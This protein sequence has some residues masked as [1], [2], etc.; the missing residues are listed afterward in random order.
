MNVENNIKSLLV[1]SSV[2]LLFFLQESWSDDKA[3]NLEN[4]LIKKSRDLNISQSYYWKKL[5]HYYN[6]SSL[7]KSKSFFLSDK[8]SNNLQSELEGNLRA[9]LDKDISKQ[10]DHNICKFPARF[11]FILKSL[12]VDRKTFPNPKC[13]KYKNHISKI[14]ANNL[15]ISFASESAN[16][17]ISMMGHVFLKISGTTKEGRD[18]SHALG[19]FADFRKSSVFSIIFGSISKGVDGLYLLEPYKKKLELY[20]IKQ[21]RNVWNYNI[22]LSSTQID[23]L[24][25]HIWELKNANVTYHFITNNCGS[26]LLNLLSLVEEKLDNYDILFDAPIDIIKRLYEIGYIKSVELVPSDIGKYQVLSKNLTRQDKK[27]ILA[28][29]E[30]DDKRDFY[31]KN[32]SNK[33]DNI[34]YV[35]DLVNEHKLSKKPQKYQEDY[36]V[37][38]EIIDEEFTNLG[39]TNLNLDIRNPINKT[40]SSVLDFG[41]ESRKS[42]NEYLRFGFYPVYNDIKDDN[43]NYFNEFDLQLLNLNAFYNINED[44]LLFEKL[45]I[46]KIKNINDYDLIF[47]GLSKSLNISLERQKL[48]SLSN[49]MFFDGNAGLGYGDRLFDDLLVYAISKVGL[50]NFASNDIIYLNPEVGLIYQNKNSD[51]K[52]ILKLQKFYANDDF[53][54][55]NLYEFNQI[56]YLNSNSEIILKYQMIDPTLETKF[57]IFGLDY[58]YHF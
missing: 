14:A 17:V 39:N 40:Y 49:K 31:R 47:S 51:F 13:T 33:N 9:F 42:N 34:L 12:G 18:V 58:R 8:G 19:Y 7:V 15:S 48:N 20:N 29:F 2:F 38:K 41:Y 25:D 24:V 56:Y 5:L 54:Y 6:G 16:S 35:I 44:R 45:D 28:F 55:E 4:D 10:D 11:Q 57:D 23:K 27:N 26:A 32:F 3:L 36:V 30:K 50:S 52:T 53:K 43:S 1:L 22:K 37:I 46:I 21:N